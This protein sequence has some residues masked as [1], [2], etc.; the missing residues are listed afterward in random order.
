MMQPLITRND[1]AR[2]RQI[3]KTPNDAKLNEMILDAQLLDLQPLLGENL[4]NKILALPEDYTELLD[5][6]VYEKDGISYTNYGVKM[7]LAYFT[8][9]RYLMF[10][11]V[12][13]TPYSVVEKLNSE[14]R[15]AEASSKKSIYQNNRDAA[16]KLWQ[17]V[18][19]WLLRT[20]NEDYKKSC[21]APAAQGSMRFTKIS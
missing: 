17:S 13:D 20:S 15:P 19:N 10:G 12:T 6:C 5:G 14:S 1:I 4:F 8:Y 2:Y 7:V 16:N 11:S 21:N 18:H 9:A 3:S